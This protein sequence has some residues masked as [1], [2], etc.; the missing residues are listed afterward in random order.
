MKNKKYVYAVAYIRAL[1]AGLLTSQ[2]K[3]QL[4]ETEDAENLFRI[5]HGTSYA[6]GKD[7]LE[8][9]LIDESI[10]T[11]LLLK[12]L[13]MDF[14]LTKLLTLKYDFH[15]IKVLLKNKHFPQ[16]PRLPLIEGGNLNLKELKSAISKNKMPGLPTD[17][18]DAIREAETKFDR[19]NKLSTIDM[20]LDKAFGNIFYKCSLEYGNKFFIEIII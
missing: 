20:V 17:Y 18:V 10:K 16:V 3:T 14:L 9:K 15:N 7:L 2:I 19:T 13:S 6:A 8:Q 1:E 4:L 5:L 12:K 11:I